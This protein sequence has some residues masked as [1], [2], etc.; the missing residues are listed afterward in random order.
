MNGCW[1]SP[2]TGNPIQEKHESEGDWRDLATK[3]LPAL[4]KLDGTYRMLSD[5]NIHMA[6]QIM[7]N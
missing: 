6:R 7:G 4:K 5:A 1:L 3:K 2:V